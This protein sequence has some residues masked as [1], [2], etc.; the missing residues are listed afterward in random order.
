LVLQNVKK[1]V[2]SDEW[3]ETAEVGAD[4]CLGLFVV[5]RYGSLSAD[6]MEQSLKRAEDTQKAWRVA[7]EKWRGKAEV[8]ADGCLGPFVVCFYGSL[9]AGP[10]GASAE[11]GRGHA[12]S[13]GE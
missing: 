13:S 7:S 3:R 5:C 4:G 6:L 12:K 10:D 2:A 8:G 11:A 9:S 1:A